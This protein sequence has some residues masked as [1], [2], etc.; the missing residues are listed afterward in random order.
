PDGNGLSPEIESQAEYLRNIKS[1]NCTACHQ[2]GNEATREIP[3]ALGEFESTV[4]AWRRRLRSG[5][6]GG[7]M[8]SSVAY[9]GAEGTLAMF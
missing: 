2:L 9:L 7:S 6:A 1:G 5:Q 4:E 3:E 8:T